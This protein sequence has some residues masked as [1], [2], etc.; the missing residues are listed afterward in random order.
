MKREVVEVIE[1]ARNL[2]IKIVND[3]G[4][5]KVIMGGSRHDFPDRLKAVALALEAFDRI[6]AKG[7]DGLYNSSS[8][9]PVKLRQAL[10]G[11][12][13][14]FRIMNISIEEPHEIVA[15]ALGLSRA[16]KN[17]AKPILRY[18]NKGFRNSSNGTAMSGGKPRKNINNDELRQNLKAKM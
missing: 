12:F 17:N 14:W 15:S 9:D 1:S 16:M 11:L 5:S 7:L 3:S 6:G 18:N 4:N 2:Q 8:M 10:D 13:R